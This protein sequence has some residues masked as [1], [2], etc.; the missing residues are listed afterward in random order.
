MNMFMKKIFGLILFLSYVVSMNAQIWYY[1]DADT[2]ITTGASSRAHD[3]HFTVVLVQDSYGNLWMERRFGD[4]SLSALNIMKD[5]FAINRNFY[6]DAFNKSEHGT[7]PGFSLQ[8][9]VVDYNSPRSYSDRR[10]G[11]VGLRG[12]FSFVKLKLVERLQKCN[13][14]EYNHGARMRFAIGND[15]K[16]IIEDPD[17]SNPIYY[18]SY[19]PDSFI[20]HTNADDLF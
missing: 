7:K 16:T 10:L 14:Y 5:A 19:S 17:R 20:T 9:R 8:D 18:K 6:I 3:G 11:S 4:S 15:F 13:V 2:D 12:Y 1:V